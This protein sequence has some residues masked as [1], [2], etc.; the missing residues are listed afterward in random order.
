MVIGVDLGVG[1]YGIGVAIGVAIGVNVG[2]IGN[3]GFQLDRGEYLSTKLKIVDLLFPVSPWPGPYLDAD[4]GYSQGQIMSAGGLTRGQ[5][6]GC[7]Q[8]MLGSVY[9]TASAEPELLAFGKGR[10]YYLSRRGVL[11]W[12]WAKKKGYFGDD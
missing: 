10:M 2:V 8:R 9:L 4:P 3:A 7:L 5:V 6:S 11:F 12:Y 1:I